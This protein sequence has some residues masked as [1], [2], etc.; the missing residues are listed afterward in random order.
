MGSVME[1]MTAAIADGGKREEKMC[2]SLM[3]FLIS[4]PF[5]FHFLISFSFAEAKVV[6]DDGQRI[7]HLNIT[8]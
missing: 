4:F 1:K 2:I 3:S 5:S 8:S 6:I 7:C